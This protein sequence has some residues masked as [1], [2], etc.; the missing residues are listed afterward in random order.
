MNFK[1]I[2]NQITKIKFVNGKGEIITTKITNNEDL[3]KSLQIS[4]GLLGI[5]L[6]L[7]IEAVP[8]YALHLKYDK[9][10]FENIFKELE[11][12]KTENRNF[13][14]YWFPHSKYIQTKVTNITKVIEIKEKRWSLHCICSMISFNIH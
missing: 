12:F 2:A 1:T 8:S 13:E 6:E 10:T 3:F 11:K 7:T 5:I 14:F 4:L 9:T